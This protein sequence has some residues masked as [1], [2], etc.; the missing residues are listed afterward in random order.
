MSEFADAFEGMEANSDWFASGSGDSFGSGFDSPSSSRGATQRNNG[1]R[2]KGGPAEAGPG[3]ASYMDEGSFGWGEGGA[4]GEFDSE[5]PAAAKQLHDAWKQD[6]E[7]D[8]WAGYGGAGFDNQIAAVAGDNPLLQQL[9]SMPDNASKQ[10]Q[11][12]QRQAPSGRQQRQP[13]ARGGR[14][15]GRAGRG[16]GGRAGATDWKLAADSP[17]AADG[18]EDG[19]ADRMMWDGNDRVGLDD[20]MKS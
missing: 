2:G 7:P 12:Q 19:W 4:S 18:F 1:Q 8:F 5:G 9:A 11:R 10:P 16:A 3:R 14:R 17:D 20:V 6:G 15:G 13:A